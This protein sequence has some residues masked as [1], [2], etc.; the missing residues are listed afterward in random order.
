V[1]EA[2]SHLAPGNDQGRRLLVTTL[3]DG[4]MSTPLPDF[5]L[6]VFFSEWEFTARYHLT[7][8]DAETL[9]VSEVLALATDEERAAFAELPL[10]YT[11][12]WGS[13]SLR[14]AIAST[15]ETLGP[16]H[17]LTFA[18]AEEGMFWA[19][20]ELLGPGDHGVVTVPNYESM[21]SL[22]VHTGAT[23][24]GLVLRP[25]DGWRIDLSEFERLL[26]PE[27]RVVAVNFPN[28]P[29]GA[30]PDRDTF[31]QLSALCHER[32]IR[33][34]SDEVYRGIELDPNLTLPQAADLAPRAISLNVMS[35]AYGLPGL[36]I[37]WLASKDRALLERLER[38]KHYTSICSSAPSE[39]LATIA[40][41]NGD[42][43]LSRNRAIVSENLPLFDA[44]FDARA[45]QFAWERPQGGCV[46]FPRLLTG[47]TTDSF[48][49]RLVKTAGVLLLPADIYASDL[50][51]VANDRFRVGVGRRNP[52]PALEAFAA[53]MDSEL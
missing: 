46:C 41:H 6:E 1:T 39:H 42:Q 2:G 50:G 52:A 10:G 13:E 53:F 14:E 37:G 18:G 28:N 8:S 33:L 15:Y 22:M 45:E 43:I 36:R 9:T 35:K 11:P 24:D 19:L 30:V 16:E 20:Q 32:G 31:I 5:R 40:L 51:A 44:F 34:F 3:E 48:C 12:T 27:T 21:E 25:E 38:R 47:E 17:V 4:E 49:R 29:T 23:I 26:H 7:A